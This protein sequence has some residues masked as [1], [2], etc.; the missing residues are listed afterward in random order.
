MGVIWSDHYCHAG[1]WD[2]RFPSIA[3]H[4]LLTR[5]VT[6]KPNSIAL[7]FYGRQTRYA[8]LLDQARRFARGLQQ[9]GLG[10]GNRVG[11]FLPNTPHYPAAYYG[12]LLAGATVVNFSPLYS[13]DE[14]LAQAQ[15]AAIDAMVCLDL[16]RLW[17]PVQRLLD[18]RAVAQV[19]VG[20]LGEVL[21]TFKAIG[22]RL[23]KRKER[24]R[25]PADGRVTR[26]ATLLD[27]DGAFQPSTVDSERDIA[28]LQ[29]TGG[30]TGVPK[31]AAL[32]HANLSVNALQLEAIDPQ[33][34]RAEGRVLG[35]LPLFHIF[36]NTAILNRSVLS[37]AEIVLLPKFEAGEALAAI[38]RR[39]CT[40]MA[41]VPAMFQALIDHP[42]CSAATF[43]SVQQA[44][45]GG[46]AMTPALKE[47]FETVTN[48]RVLEGYGMT[49]SAGVVS[50]NPFRGE[51]RAG[52]VGQPLPGTTIR[53]L[54]EDGTEQPPGERGEIVVSG[55]QVMTGYWRKDQARV[56]LLADGQF[57]TGD[58]GLIERDGYLRIVDRIKDMINVGGFKVFPS[59]LEAILARH[60]AVAEAIVIAA[61]DERVGERPKAFV[62]LHPDAQ[63]GADEL[64]AF[65]NGKIGKHERVADLEIRPELPKTL[66]GKPDRKALQ[67]EERARH[68]TAAEPLVAV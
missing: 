51:A 38:R 55:P 11:L 13:P 34:P 32:S 60:P 67:A 19:I 64:K 68:A 52:T 50:V 31:G 44:F 23:F 2:E 25:L 61:A 27:N 12:A 28:L 24:Q 21:P 29:Y 20:T 66:I 43:E 35:C 65:L 17:P 37:A 14:V 16:A 45:S 47:R 41:G 15:D 5:S 46:A 1:R 54:A 10:R 36:A 39:R 62:A 40:D 8:E 22:F 18:E 49:E 63:A 33:R 42:S 7:D 56:E 4:D 6:A 53:I 57:A 59:Q 26:W 9:S 3:V 48:A 30:T 58:I